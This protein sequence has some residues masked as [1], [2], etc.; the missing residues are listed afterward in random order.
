MLISLIR[1]KYFRDEEK[2]KLDLVLDAMGA[3]INSVS[4]RDF[5]LTHEKFDTA[6]NLSNREIYDT[7]LTGNEDNG[8]GNDEEADLDLVMIGQFNEDIIG[9][10]RQGRIYIYRNKFTEKSI[11]ELAGFY[12]H[13]YCHLLNFDD[14]TTTGPAYNVPYE[15]GSIVMQL[16]TEAERVFIPDTGRRGIAKR[17]TRK[18]INFNKSI[19]EKKKRK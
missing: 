19:I 5:I 1:A 9:Y 7:I 10:T 11:S 17:R 18:R 8:E 4:F 15:V 14:P 6:N 13:E 12:A 2:R 16:A 3:A